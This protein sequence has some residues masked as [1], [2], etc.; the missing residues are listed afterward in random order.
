MSEVSYQLKISKMEETKKFDQG[1][2]D[3]SLLDNEFVH[4]AAKI[5]MFGAE[6][7]GRDN[8]RGGTQWNRAYSAAKRHIDA[9]WDGEDHDSESG[10]CHLYHAACNLMFLS[11][12]KR[13]GLGVDNRY[14]MSKS[15]YEINN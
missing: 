13:N 4:G 2:T 5:L 10:E 3:L 14:N 8:W 12:W 11:Y 9:F 15:K 7:Y 6:K 1:K